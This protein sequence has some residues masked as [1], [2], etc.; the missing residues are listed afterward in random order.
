MD[1]KKS[2]KLNP[3]VY[4][5]YLSLNQ[6]SYEALLRLAEKEPDLYPSQIMGHALRFAEANGLFDYA[7]KTPSQPGQR[8]YVPVKEVRATRAKK[9]MELYGADCT[10]DSCSFNRYEVTPTGVIIRTSQALGLAQIPDDPDAVRK[11]VL[12]NFATISQA[13]EAFRA[14][15]NEVAE[16]EER[17]IKPKSKKDDKKSK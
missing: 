8:G 17:I 9:L 1:F 14:Q 12:G 11:L 7:V 2:R 13:E 16:P 4:K 3:K 10:K 5:T 6:A 15:S